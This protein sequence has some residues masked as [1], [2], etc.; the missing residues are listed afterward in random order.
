M[1]AVKFSKKHIF[2]MQT[3]SSSSEFRAHS[4]ITLPR[5]VGSAAP[6]KSAETAGHDDLP[7]PVDHQEWKRA[8]NQPP[9]EMGEVHV[10]TL[11]FKQMK[12]SNHVHFIVLLVH[13]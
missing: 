12:T 7:S 5:A 10:I 1:L 11:T 2:L 6:D 8:L 13:P 9:E 4:P 3:P